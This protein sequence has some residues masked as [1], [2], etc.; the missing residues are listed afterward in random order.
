MSVVLVSGGTVW[1]KSVIKRLLRV[2]TTEANFS[3][4]SLSIRPPTQRGQSGSETNYCS[5]YVI[6]TE[7]ANGADRWKLSRHFSCSV[8]PAQQAYQQKLHAV[9]S[10]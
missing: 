1:L 3:S 2:R 7:R 4:G 5:K 9:I 6:A 8:S 10:P